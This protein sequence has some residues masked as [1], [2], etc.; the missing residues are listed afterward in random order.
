[1]DKEFENKMNQSKSQKYYSKM[2]MNL[3]LWQATPNQ[4][5]HQILFRT[6]SVT[7]RTEFPNFIAYI[8]SGRE[9]FIFILSLPMTNSE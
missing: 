3:F 9:I 8:F 6:S 7:G 2:M 5:V 4:K 1:M